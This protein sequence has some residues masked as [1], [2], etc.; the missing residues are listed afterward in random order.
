VIISLDGFDFI[1]N[2]SG[3]LATVNNVGPGFSVVGSTGNYSGFSVL[4]KLV[5]C[6]DMLA[7]RL[8]LYPLLL[9]FAPSAWKKN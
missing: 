8:E 5:F 2:F 3:V 1:T 9:L 4:S 6:F 7:G